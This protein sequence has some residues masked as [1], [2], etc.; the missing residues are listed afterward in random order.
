MTDRNSIN[1]AAELRTEIRRIAATELGRA[2]AAL[3]AGAAKGTARAAA[4]SAFK[5]RK[6]LKRVRALYRLVSSADKQAFSREEQ[7]LTAI[8]HRLAEL[9][10][11]S[12]MAEAATG[13]ATQFAEGSQE[14]RLL[15]RL[16]ARLAK[17]STEDKDNPSVLLAECAASCRTAALKSH[18]MKAPRRHGRAERVLQNGIEHC[19]EGAAKCLAVARATNEAEDWHRFRTRMKQ[20]RLQLRLL[21]L[22]WPGEMLLRSEAAARL[23]DALGEDHDLSNLQS[24]AELES[25]AVEWPDGM[26]LLCSMIQTRQRMLREEADHLGSILLAEP[27]KDTAR[28]IITL[29]SMTVKATR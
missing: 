22:A 11:R 9:R 4:K 26:A 24:F 14:A 1:P 8:G 16:V 20:H 25:D 2:A 12:A 21:Q 17:T 7:E 5:A 15:E 19:L 6:A 27:A 29:W 18:E 13:L 3:E 10:D 23:T 28:R